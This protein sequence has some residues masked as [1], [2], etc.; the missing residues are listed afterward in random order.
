MPI[1]PVTGINTDITTERI[2][3]ESE[4]VIQEETGKMTE[5]PPPPPAYEVDISEEAKNLQAQQQRNQSVAPENVN[6]TSAADTSDNASLN[7][8]G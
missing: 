4:K 7:V 1:D 3:S 5:A 8:V 6:T 2:T